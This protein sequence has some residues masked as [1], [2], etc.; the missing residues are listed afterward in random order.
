VDEVVSIGVV[1][2]ASGRIDLSLSVY[3][4]GRHSR[5]GPSSGVPIHGLRPV[6]LIDAA[7]KDHLGESL[8]AALR[9]RQVLAWAAWIEA[10]FLGSL[11]GESG[12]DWRPRIIDVRDLV[13][14]LDHMAATPTP[15]GESLVACAARYGVPP[16]RAHH[17]LGDALMTAELFLVVAGR[18]ERRGLGTIRQL[19]R[20]GSGRRRP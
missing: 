4:E 14:H 10:A 13:A 8:G 2:I 5:P 6:D 9:G 17:A 7:E 11:L 1:P 19:Q 3:G 12:R 20:L 18:L 16:A 15:E